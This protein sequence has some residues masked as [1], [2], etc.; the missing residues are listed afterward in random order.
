MR[1]ADE[2]E[3]KL[4]EIRRWAM[5]L[6]AANELHKYG[7]H[8]D[9]RGEVAFD[10]ANPMNQ[11]TL[12]QQWDEEAQRQLIATAQEQ[13]SRF[14]SDLDALLARFRAYYDLDSLNLTA[15]VG[16]LGG[17]SAEPPPDGPPA[18]IHDRIGYADLTV[19][20]VSALIVEWQWQGDA[21]QTFHSRFLVPFH[22]T[23]LR[24]RAYVY[25]MAVTAQTLHD[26]VIAI[27]NALLM[28]AEECLAALGK[29]GIPPTEEEFASAM[30]GLSIASVVFGALSLFPPLAPVAGPISLGAGVVTLAA[31]YVVDPRANPGVAEVGADGGTVWEVIQATWQTLTTIEQ[32]F[33]DGDVKLSAALAE[34]LTSERALANP[35]MAM[36][37]PQIANP[38]AETF[39]ALTLNRS[40]GVPLDRDPVVLTVVAL[41]R[42]GKVNLAGAAGQY[43]QASRE[44]AFCM[45]PGSLARFFPRSVEEFED[46]R[47]RLD[48]LLTRTEE[49]LD[50]AGVAVVDAATA[51]QLSDD[52]AAEFIRRT[53]D[54]RTP[55]A[56]PE[57]GRVGGV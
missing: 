2:L 42:A 21:A 13:T 54:L 17:Q 47:I 25:Q 22:D 38:G 43:A 26:Y 56:V 28:A 32:S 19:A 57:P 35:G 55:S 36:D 5:E 1:L 31:P 16:L 10:W 8:F 11:P 27:G 15:L 33:T 34:V 6:F 23:S 30:L 40:T 46:A 44:L 18:T 29:P 3:P 9:D 7:L 49:A 50:A 51:F 37:P 20:E 45:T 12:G 41:Y 53:A 48:G 24:Q 14:N 52:Q 4:V 39:E